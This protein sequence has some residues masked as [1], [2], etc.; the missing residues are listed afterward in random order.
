MNL[1]ENIKMERLVRSDQLAATLQPTGR[2]PG[3]WLTCYPIF[4]EALRDGETIFRRL[5]AHIKLAALNRTTISAVE[6]AIKSEILD[7]VGASY[8]ELDT[9]SV[10]EAVQSYLTGHAGRENSHASRPYTSLEDVAAQ[11]PATN[12]PLTTRPPCVLR[13][14][15]GVFLD[16]WMSF[17]AYRAR[18]DQT[19]PLLAIDWLDLHERLRLITSLPGSST[20]SVASPLL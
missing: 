1:R 7:E 2:V 3:L 14:G 9:R 5:P 8:I 4:R 20:H 19:I 16:G 6:Q 12:Y 18:G 17:F 10:D 11:I 13:P 15:K